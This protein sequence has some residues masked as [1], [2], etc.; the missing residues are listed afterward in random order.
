MEKHRSAFVWASFLC[1][2]PYS[3]FAMI[4]KS[5]C[6]QVRYRNVSSSS[7]TP[8]NEG[9]P[10]ASI[11]LSPNTVREC[12]SQS[13]KCVLISALEGSN[14]SLFFD[15]QTRPTFYDQHFP[16]DGTDDCL[17]NFATNV[18]SSLIHYVDNNSTGL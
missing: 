18:S 15:N 6:S 13:P 10:C 14:T 17:G 2:S 8:A 12:L 4:I 11:C 16:L 3:F 1:L 7:G 5:S 9:R